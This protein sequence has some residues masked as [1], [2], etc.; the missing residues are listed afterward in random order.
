[1]QIGCETVPQRSLRVDSSTSGGPQ[2][3]THDWW[4]SIVPN[5][6]DQS[7]TDFAAG[8][9]EPPHL[10]RKRLP[11]EQEVLNFI[12]LEYFQT[13]RPSKPEEFNGF[14]HYM[15][16]VRNVLI[17]DVKS[18]SLILTVKCDSLEILEGL[19][20]DYCTGYLTEM[21]QKYL[22]TEEVLKKFGL[23]AVKL[24]TTILKEEYR[25]CQSYFL[26]I[27]GEF[28]ISYLFALFSSILLIA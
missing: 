27:L 28:T 18:G 14:L 20:E 24:T 8:G 1:M 4:K 25:T 15:E 21:A 23:V 9:F 10:G 17:L 7:Q 5:A 3:D 2:A 22:V 26:Q 16:K 19:W 6:S 12:A 11:S 13:V